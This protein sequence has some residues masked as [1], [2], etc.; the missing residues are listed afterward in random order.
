M[1][2]LQTMPTPTQESHMLYLQDDLLNV[3][4]CGLLAPGLCEGL[5]QLS[6]V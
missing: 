2:P 4:Q 1:Q 5:R 6:E 3:L